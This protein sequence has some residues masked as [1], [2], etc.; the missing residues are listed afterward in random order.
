MNW[1]ITRVCPKCGNQLLLLSEGKSDIYGEIIYHFGCKCRYFVFLSILERE[2]DLDSDELLL[3][4]KANT[5]L[6]TEEIKQFFM[7]KFPPLI[8]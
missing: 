1:H 8:H 6:T 4:E 5:K 3:W 2:M 7:D